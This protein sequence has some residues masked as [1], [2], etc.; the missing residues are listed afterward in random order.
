MHT[1]ILQEF[2]NTAKCSN[3]T[4]QL[5]YSSLFV[6]CY[7]F[8]TCLAPLT[9]L[10]S[11]PLTGVHRDAYAVGDRLGKVRLHEH[12]AFLS[13]SGS[14]LFIFLSSIPI[15]ALPRISQLGLS[16][17]LEL[18]T[19]QRLDITLYLLTALPLRSFTNRKY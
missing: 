18:A 5:S 4:S 15:F 1:K 11:L 8:V 9:I 17:S 6:R 12:V 13:F 10:G 7:W 14:H 2:G 19:R 3:I 16:F